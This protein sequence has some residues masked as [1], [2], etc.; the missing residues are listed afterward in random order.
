VLSRFLLLTPVARTTGPPGHRKVELLPPHFLTGIGK[1]K[2]CTEVSDREAT[3]GYYQVVCDGSAWI[4]LAV[5]QFT[6]PTAQH[7][8]PTTTINQPDTRRSPAPIADTITAA[9]T[10]HWGCCANPP[11]HT[12]ITAVRIDILNLHERLRYAGH[13]LPE[14]LRSGHFPRREP[15]IGAGDWLLQSKLRYSAIVLQTIVR[16]RA[17]VPAVHR[18]RFLLRQ[19]AST[20]PGRKPTPTQVSRPFLVR[21]VV[22]ILFVARQINHGH[23]AAIKGRLATLEGHAMRRHSGRGTRSRITKVGSARHSFT[24]AM[25]ISACAAPANTPCGRLATSPISPRI[26]CRSRRSWRKS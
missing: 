12:P 10:G 4:C 13:E 5:R 7:N 9:T 22:M 3:Y 11:A 1:G 17:V 26:R 16:S 20:S 23:P 18:I 2:C 14:F 21:A 24:R 25:I 8:R 6:G 19:P 15:C